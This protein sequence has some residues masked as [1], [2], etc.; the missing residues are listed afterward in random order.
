VADHIDHIRDLIGTAHLGIGSDYDGIPTVPVGLEDAST[1]PDLFVELVR[2]GYSDDELKDIAGRS[3][4][5][6]MR[7]AEATARRLQA[8]EPPAD[9]LIEELD[10]EDG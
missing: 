4:L 6:A 3:F 5:R 7:A 1:F 2:R 9:D 8:M 10:G